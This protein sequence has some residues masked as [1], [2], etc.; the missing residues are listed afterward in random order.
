MLDGDIDFT[1]NISPYEPDTNYNVVYIIDTSVSIDAVEL[2]TIKDAYTDLTN[3][4]VDEGIADNINFGVVSY[5]SGGR[6]L[7][8]C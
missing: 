5:D 6:I 1:L 4:Y 2:Q 3:F 7:H 8:Q